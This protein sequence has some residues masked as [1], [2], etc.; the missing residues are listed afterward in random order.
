[1]PAVQIDIRQQYSNEIEL[2]IID[3]VQLSIVNAFK[4]PAID[5]DIR[6]YVH[7]PH[8]FQC[9]PNLRSPEFYTLIS[10]DCFT[11]RSIE[12]KRRLYQ[13]IVE[14]LAVFGIP[15]NHIKIIL[16]E[17]PKENWGI[18]GGI[19]ACDIDLGFDICI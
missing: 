4:I 18:R 17:I 7:Q 1:M 14:S 12:A 3:A 10:I 16:R 11:G 8:R 13:G 19:A 9:P 2:K 6:L 15:K 5:R